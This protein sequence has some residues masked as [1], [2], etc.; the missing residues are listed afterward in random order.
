MDGL[1]EFNCLLSLFSQHFCT[2][3]LPRILITLALVATDMLLELR[4]GW[5]PKLLEFGLDHLLLLMKLSDVLENIKDAILV[6][7]SSIS[8]VSIPPQ[9]VH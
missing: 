3:S 6:I 4:H 1:G 5:V 7:F 8:N 9:Q 2:C